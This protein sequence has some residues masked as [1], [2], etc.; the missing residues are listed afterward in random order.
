MAAN[1]ITVSESDLGAGIDQQ[2]AESRIQPGFSEDL[3]NVDP[4]PE[5][6]LAKRP[7]YQGVAGYI[8]VRVSRVDWSNEAEDNLCFTLDSNIDLNNTNSSPIIVYGRLSIPAATNVPFKIYNPPTSGDEAI[9][10]PKFKVDDKKSL[11]LSNTSISIPFD[12]HNQP[13]IFLT[14]TYLPT[15]TGNEAFYLN[16]YQINQSTLDLLL[17]YN[18]SQDTDVFVSYKSLAPV[19]GSVHV[20]TISFTANVAS[21]ITAATHGLSSFNILTEFFEDDSTTWTTVEPNSVIIAPNGDVS[22]TF[23]QSV[24]VTCVLRSVAFSQRKVFDLTPGDGSYTISSIPSHYLDVQVYLKN[25]NTGN[26]EQVIP[27]SVIV[28][29]ENNTATVNWTNNVFELDEEMVLRSVNYTDSIIVYEPVPVLSN[30]LCVT[31]SPQPSASG[32]DFDPQMTL[33]GIPHSE[34]YSDNTIYD[35]NGWTTHIDSYRAAGNNRVIAGLGGNLFAEY[36]QAEV[37]DTYLLPTLYPNIRSR[38]STVN[39]YGHVLG[40]AFFGLTEVVPWGTGNNQQRLR[41]NN[42]FRFSGGEEGIATAV[43]AEWQ[44]GNTVRYTLSCPNLQYNE[45]D[46]NAPNLLNQLLTISQSSNPLN[47][48]TFKITSYSADLGNGVLSI[49]VENPYRA[50]S[51]G[52]ESYSMMQAS[53]LTDTLPLDSTGTFIYGDQILSEVIEDSQLVTVVESIGSSVILSGITEPIIFNDKQRIVAQRTGTII[54]CKEAGDTQSVENLVRGDMLSIT[55]LDRKVRISS[56]NPSATSAISFAG[57]VVSGIPDTSLLAVG[58]RILIVNAG[59]WSGE[60]VVAEIIDATSLRIEKDLSNADPLPGGYSPRLVGKTIEIDENLQITDEIDGGVTLSVGSRW[61]PLEAPDDSFS[62]TDTTNER[63]FKYRNPGDQGIIKS[64]MVSDNMYFTNGEDSTL[65][66]DGAALVRAGLPNWQP[67]MFVSLDTTAVA[68]IK[69]D[70]TFVETTEQRAG[71]LFKL[72][73]Y[74]SNAFSVGDTVEIYRCTNAAPTVPVAGTIRIKAKITK[75]WIDSS[76]SAHDFIQIDYFG[77]L[78]SALG[79]TPLG[80]PSERF[81]IYQTATYK[82]YFRLAALD[83]NDNLLSSAVT[84]VD[85]CTVE[86]STD[87]QIRIRLSRMP[88]WD[89][90]DYDKLDLQVYRTK[91]NG[92]APYYLLQSLP[93]KFNLNEQYIDFVDARNDDTLIQLDSVSTAL[94]GAELG[95]QWSAPLRS[96]YITSAG[97][98]LVQGNIKNDPA[99]DIYFQKNEGDTAIVE[100][101]FTSEIITLRK[102]NSSTSNISDGENVQR[103][104]FVASGTTITATSISSGVVTVSATGTWTAGHWV[105]LYRQGVLDGMQLSISGWHKITTGGTGSFTITTNLSSLPALASTANRVARATS[106]LDIPVYINS[107]DGNYATSVGNTAVVELRVMMRLAQAINAQQSVASS[108]WVIAQ[109]GNLIGNGRLLLTQP[110]VIDSIFGIQVTT[111]LTTDMQLFANDLRLPRTINGSPYYKADAV[112]YEYPSR[113]LISYP[114]FPEIFS[115]PTATI[116]SESVSVVDVNSADGQEITGIIPFFGESAFGAAQKSGVVVVFKTNSIYLVDIAAKVSGINPVQRIESQGLG[117]TA[118]HSIANTRDGIM[119]ANES[120]LYRLGRNL[121]IEYVGQKIERVWRERVNRS[122]LDRVFGHHYG[123]GSQYKVSVP[124]DGNTSPGD[125]LVYSHVREYRGG[126]GAWTRYSDHPAIGW[127][128]LFSDA[129]FATT[130]G[131]VMSVRRTGGVSD[132]RDDNRPIEMRALLRAMD[133]G[134]AG[135]RKSVRFLVVKFRV[136]ADTSSTLL[137]TARDLVDNFEETDTF[138]LND[139]RND[140]TGLQDPNRIKIKSIRFSP[141]EK[142]SI[143]FQPLILNGEIDQPVEIVEVSYRVTGM[144]DKGME[145]AAE[146]K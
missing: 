111:G 26:L 64:T 138:S 115:N 135:I 72:P 4:Q 14:K 101:D 124:L 139:T 22:I 121:A 116:D 17:S 46:N 43:S 97:N 15:P 107:D 94:E 108:P 131:Q 69:L 28:N 27:D 104:E 134:D 74:S 80:G 137:Y 9:Y 41:S 49:D 114:N 126:F 143:Y 132:Y 62:L 52:D 146:T 95:T 141:K 58:Q 48:G 88:V 30:K 51:D 6:Y 45:G 75:L 19:S 60:Q 3:V 136:V 91:K 128:N 99:L 23:S 85:D 110:K 20:Q 127:A 33:W 78:D 5:G 103:F 84:S 39:L 92:V 133:F 100:A 76:S 55:G 1:F 71:A 32:V 82:Y 36:Q 129:Y 31:I 119:F 18:I 44:S 96:K 81:R 7:G 16:N 117:C 118:P 120:G 34:I 24:T 122:L 2:S 87:A 140:L 90:Y 113:V 50:D 144:T 102:N 93:L 11:L 79:S 38:V 145:E 112:S 89:I 12:E 105:Y 77:D 63:Y 130:D 53:I 29:T 47:S 56:I 8:P 67:Q 37:G 66:W 106:G 13:S 40:P 142:E 10:F 21:T 83:N 123:T 57:S 86:M 125:L 109:A 25:A 35:K 61:I 42:Y 70:R 68:K 73:H 65:K 54:P 59:E 98:R